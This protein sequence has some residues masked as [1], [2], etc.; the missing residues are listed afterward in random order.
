MRSNI[1]I[2]KRSVD[3]LPRDGNRAILWDNELRGFGVLVLPSGTKSYVVNYRATD[4]R[5]RR[6]TLGQHGRLTPDQ[7]R[8]LA[9]KHLGEIAGGN[10]PA[11]SRR[12][13]SMQASFAALCEDFI[14]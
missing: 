4:G 12:A 11:E 14:A 8:K 7:A 5:Y 6:I 3:A 2:T 1:R 13:A 10:D 9:K